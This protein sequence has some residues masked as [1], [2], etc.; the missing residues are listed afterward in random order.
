MI[1]PGFLAWPGA[2]FH[3]AAR[4]GGSPSAV[5][6]AVAPGRAGHRVTLIGDDARDARRGGDRLSI[7]APGFPAARGGPR[8]LADTPG[9]ETILADLTTLAR[10]ERHFAPARA[11]DTLGDPA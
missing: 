10:E 1:R 11:L 3:H 8:R 7:A 6:L 2:A 9:L 4:A 5:D